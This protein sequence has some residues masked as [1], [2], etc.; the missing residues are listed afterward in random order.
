[1]KYI[2]SPPLRE[3]SNQAALWEALKNGQIDTVGTDHCPFD[4]AQKLMGKDAFTGIPNGMPGVEERVNLMYT[5]GVKRG[6][7]DLQ[8][9][10]DVLSTRAAKLFGTGLLADGCLHQRWAGKKQP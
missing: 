1:M 7:L 5:Y 10:V 8:R 9:F 4:L 2:M 3:K 6:G